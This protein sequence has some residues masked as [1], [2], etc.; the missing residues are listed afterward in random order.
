MR[1]RLAGA[2]FAASLATTVL[3]TPV[4][5]DAVNNGH[6]CVGDAASNTPPTLN[7]PNVADWATTQGPRAMAERVVEV[8]VNYGCWE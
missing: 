8:M 7:G 6:N 2:V 3:L 4:A 5:A 1:K